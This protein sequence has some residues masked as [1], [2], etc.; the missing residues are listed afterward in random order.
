MLLLTF[1]CLSSTGFGQA[2]T[3]PRPYG[4]QDQLRQFIEQEMVYPDSALKHREQG[5]V[6]LFFIVNADGST[7]NL[8]VW[9]SVSPELDREAKRIFQKVL[10]KPGIHGGRPHAFEHT[11]DVKFNVRKYQRWCRNRGYTTPPAPPAPDANDL[12][13]YTLTEV[14]SRPSPQFNDSSQSLPRYIARNIVYPPLAYKNSIT[15]KA[16]LFYVVEANGQLSNVEHLHYLG[17]GC[18]EEAERLLRTITWN[19]GIRQG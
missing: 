15:G 18:S 2:H 1:L 16:R 10:W 17:G 4:G 5:T 8:K 11:M 6:V 19:P 7:R 13:I 12:A 14:D 9:R 3:P